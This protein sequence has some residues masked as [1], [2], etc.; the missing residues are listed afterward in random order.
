MKQYAKAMFS[1][2]NLYWKLEGE[3]PEVSDELA[4][5][6]AEHA[7]NNE[8]FLCSLDSQLESG[9]SGKLDVFWS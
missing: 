2:E 9:T 3:Q 4:E 8:S 6:W 5:A 7:P 1:G